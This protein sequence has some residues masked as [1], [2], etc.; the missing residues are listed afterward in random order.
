MYNLASAYRLAGQLD[1]ALP[2]FRE[3]AAAIEIRKFDHPRSVLTLGDLARVQ[4]EQKQFGEA[5][6]RRRKLA[7]V[8]EKRAGTHSPAYATELADLG[9]NLLR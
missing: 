4:E 6:S 5:E 2:L 7:A 9:A 8:V 1:Q 3:A